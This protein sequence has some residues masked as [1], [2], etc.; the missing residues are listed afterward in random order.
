MIYILFYFFLYSNVDFIFSSFSSFSSSSPE[1]IK[2]HVYFHYYLNT[3]FYFYLMICGSIILKHLT[4]YY[5]IEKNKNSIGLMFI[6]TK[7]IMNQL[8][9]TNMTLQEYTFNRNVMWLFTTPLMLKIYCDVNNLHWTEIQIQYHIIPVL[10][11]IFI[12]PYN[13]TYTCT[14]YVFLIYSYISYCYF[15]KNLWNKRNLLFTNIYLFIW[16]LFILISAIETSGI[17]NLY[18]INIYYL[19]A[20]NISKLITGI[21]LNDYNEKEMYEKKNIDLQCIQ[22][23]SYLISNIHKY[24]EEN[25][26][27]TN[28]CSAFIEFVKTRIL[29][30]VPE[31]KTT[32]ELE[33]LQKLLPLN[34]DKSYI[35]NQV[36]A[37]THTGTTATHAKQLDMICVLFI[38]IV[39]YTKLARKYDD[40]IIFGML[41][42]IYTIFDRIIKKYSHLQKIE[43]IGDAYMV[44]GDIFRNENNHTLAIREILCFSLDLL[45]E[46][47][48]MHFIDGNEKI[49]IRIGIHIGK[50]SIGILGNEIPRLC[51]VGNTVN[52]A[53]RLQSCADVNSIQFSHHFYEKLVSLGIE[54]DSIQIFKKENIFLKHIGSV[55]TYTIY[56]NNQRPIM[57]EDEYQDCD[58]CER[59]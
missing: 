18:T 21:I 37:T 30:K 3:T 49:S 57:E 50:V 28:K 44:V 25:A 56:H 36:P 40:K 55:T 41:S 6:Y 7:Y 10:L 35:D 29:I 32:L 24:T 22:F 13:H 59:K 45:K 46:M 23:I 42:S 51:I 20:D 47:D 16:Y 8:I 12:Y 48:S 9:Y 15:M 52:M 17:V 2:D 43:T 38:D 27:L 33:L 31:N 39:N 4:N 53:S 26:I 58:N 11:N 14:Y 5:L 54:D 1:K 34:L 19:M